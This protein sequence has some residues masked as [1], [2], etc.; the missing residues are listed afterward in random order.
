MAKSPGSPTLL[1]AVSNLKKDED[2]HEIY[3]YYGD[4]PTF[5]FISCTR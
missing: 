4:E 2:S 3:T 5:C 1:H